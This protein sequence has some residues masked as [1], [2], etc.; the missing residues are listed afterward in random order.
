MV[1]VIYAWHIFGGK[2]RA[3]FGPFVDAMIPLAS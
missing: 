3:L 1:G 2:A